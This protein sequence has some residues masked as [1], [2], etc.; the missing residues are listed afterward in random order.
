MG[1]TYS[2]ACGVLVNGGTEAGHTGSGTCSH[3]GGSKFDL[4]PTTPVTNY[5]KN[6]GQFTYLGIRSDG[7]AMYKWKS[8][9]AIYAKEL[10]HWDV[11]VGC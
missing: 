11:L 9:G 4:S 2:N 1:T 10:T 5:I 3:L 7:A 6:S 8:G